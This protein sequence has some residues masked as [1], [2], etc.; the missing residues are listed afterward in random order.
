MPDMDGYDFLL[1]LA[2]EPRWREIPVL[3]L[4]GVRPTADEA[5]FLRRRVEQVIEKSDTS[6][7]KVIDLL[8][9]RLRTNDN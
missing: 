6:A 8:R 5:D 2:R 4:T 7:W 9:S 1:E 3:V